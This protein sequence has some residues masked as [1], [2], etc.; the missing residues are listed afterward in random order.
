ML[1]KVRCK[2]CKEIKTEKGNLKCYNCRISG[3]N[4]CI[5]TVCCDCS[6]RMCKNCSGTGEPNCGCYGKCSSCGTDVNRGSNG[7]PCN[8][9]KKWYCSECRHVSKCKEC[10]IEDDS[11]EDE[12]D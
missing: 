6:E 10:K 4:K 9:C 7:W 1:R 12:T 2:N 8:K 3:C 11:D 5:Q